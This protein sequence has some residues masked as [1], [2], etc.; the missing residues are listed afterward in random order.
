MS[1]LAFITC[2]HVFVFLVTR[3]SF[4]N[5]YPINTV[6]FFRIDAFVKALGSYDI[7]L[8]FSYFFFHIQIIFFVNFRVLGSV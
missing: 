8:H 7:N 1:G 3:H 6:Y 2:Y 5:L 4:S